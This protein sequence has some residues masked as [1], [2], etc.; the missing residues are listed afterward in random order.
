MTSMSSRHVKRQL[1][2][3]Q[4]D[5]LAADKLHQAAAAPKKR[6]LRAREKRKKAQKAQNAKDQ[7]RD[8][9]AIVSENLKY[10]QLTSNCRANAQAAAVMAEV[11]SDALC[12][13]RVQNDY[14]CHAF[15]VLGTQGAP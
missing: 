4:Q 10:Y 13:L 15:Q 8:V 1:A 14:T 7:Q 3:L 11:C 5:H 9:D 2:A 12:V 6:R